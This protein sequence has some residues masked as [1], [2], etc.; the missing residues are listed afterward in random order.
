MRVIGIDPGYDRL[1]YAVI[2]GDASHPTLLA[3]GLLH[4]SKQ[5]SQPERL[6]QLFTELQTLLAFWKPDAA[7]VEDLFFSTNAKTALRVSEARGMIFVALAQQHMKI[8]EF[9][10]SQIKIAV[11]GH[12]RADKHSMIK[13]TALLLHLDRPFASDDIADAAA[14]AIAALVST[15]HT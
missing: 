4:S 3:S 9:I 15:R 14:T 10:P 12:G 5:L 6:Y 7:G 11:C 1:G 2:E 8:L 13:M